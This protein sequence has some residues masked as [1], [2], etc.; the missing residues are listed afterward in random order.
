MLVAAP[1]AVFVAVL[2]FFHCSE[3]LLAYVYMRDELSITSWLITKPYAT[4]M[5][6]A[7]LEYLVESWAL[8]GLKVGNGGMGYVS[9]VGL[10]LVLLGEGIRKLGMFTAQSNFT[11]N[12]RTTQ[13]PTHVLVTRGIY[14]YIRHPGYLGWYIWCLGTQVLLANPACCIAFAIVVSGGS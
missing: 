2:T 6:F 3:F 5:A 4:A 8:P 10:A 1:I 7:V 11:H 13:D 14:R 12:I 9:W